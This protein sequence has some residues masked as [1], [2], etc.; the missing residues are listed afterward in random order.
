MAE[1]KEKK[2]FE[3]VEVATEHTQAIQK[4]NGEIMSVNEAM[5]EILN[6][7]EEIKKAVV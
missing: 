3:L 5:V 7:V 2:Q 6:K 1:K 4:P